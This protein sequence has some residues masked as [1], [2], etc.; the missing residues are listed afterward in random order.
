LQSLL[1]DPN[2]TNQQIAQFSKALSDEAGS[3]GDSDLQSEASQISSQYEGAGDG[4][5]NE[6]TGDSD[7]SALKSAGAKDGVNTTLALA[8]GSGTQPASSAPS[9]PAPAPASAQ[10]SGNGSSG[11]DSSNNGAGTGSNSASGSSSQSGQSGQTVQ[12]GTGTGFDYNVNNNTGQNAYFTYSDQEGHSKTVEIDAGKSATFE[13]GAN[14]QGIRIEESNAQGQSL[15]S[16]GLAEFATEPNGGKMSVNSDVSDVAGN[17]GESENGQATGAQS[18]TIDNNQGMVVGNDKAGSYYGYNQPYED[19]DPNDDCMIGAGNFST[20][21][22][23]TF[24]AAASGETAE[25]ASTV[26]SSNTGP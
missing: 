12:T 24:G 5:N 19:A 18:I 14:D 17:M 1:Q 2:A 20:N 23:I 10:S 3:G 26:A 7:A 15:A 16:N 8:N 6:S 11:G 4:N 21:N 9:A 22:T 25:G 13:G